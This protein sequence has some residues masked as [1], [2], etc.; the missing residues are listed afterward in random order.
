MVHFTVNICHIPPSQVERKC[1]FDCNRNEELPTA[2][3]CTSVTRKV[4]DPLL[5]LVHF[6]IIR[7]DIY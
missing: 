7:D 3:H 6:G 1:Y 4:Y 5:T 2:A